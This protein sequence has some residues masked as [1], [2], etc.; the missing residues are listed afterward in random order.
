MNT[1]SPQILTICTLMLKLNKNVKSLIK[2]S[3]KSCSA[4]FNQISKGKNS[5]KLK[6]SF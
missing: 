3:L 2:E 5:K 6:S 1:N 4:A